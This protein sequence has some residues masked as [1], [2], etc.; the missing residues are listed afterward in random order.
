MLS[1]KFKY[2]IIRGDLVIKE[3][4]TLSNLKHHKS[5]VNEIK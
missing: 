1:K 2:R 3:D 5:E 4:L